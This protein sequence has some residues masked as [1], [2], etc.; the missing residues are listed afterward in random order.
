[1]HIDSTLESRRFL[2]AFTLIFFYLLSYQWTTW[3]GILPSLS[4]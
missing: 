1:M 4:R 2:L 3:E